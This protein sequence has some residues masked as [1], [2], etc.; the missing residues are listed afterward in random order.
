MN[1]TLVLSAL[2]LV[3]ASATLAQEKYSASEAKQHI[4]ETASVCGN[5]ASAHYAPRT[6][7]RP[8]FLNLD[9]AYPKQI[10]T[11]LIWGSARSN[12]GEPE[13]R[14]ANKKVCVTGVIKDSRG[15]PRLSPSSQARSKF[16]DSVGGCK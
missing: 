15:S 10:F 13:S 4:G 9:E 16:K 11:I 12:C 8:A 5:V 2:A 3:L 14:Y 1:R 7:G 6:K